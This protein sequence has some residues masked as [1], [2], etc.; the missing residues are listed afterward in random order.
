MMLTVLV[1]AL[2]VFDIHEEHCAWE[3][4]DAEHYHRL[5]WTA[6]SGQ[7]FV[8]GLLPPRSESG[9]LQG[10][11]F[12]R[13]A[14]RQH[15]DQPGGVGHQ[16]AL[17]NCAVGPPG[18]IADFQSDR[19]LL[20]FDPV[21]EKFLLTIERPVLLEDVVDCLSRIQEQFHGGVIYYWP[22]RQEQIQEALT[23]PEGAVAVFIN[24]RDVAYTAYALGTNCGRLRIIPAEDWESVHGEG[25]LTRQDIVV[26]QEAPTNFDVRVAGAITCAPQGPLCHVNLICLQESTPNAFIPGDLEEFAPFAD[27][28]VRYEVR[29]DGYSLR[30]ATPEEAARTWEA[31]RPPALTISVPDL[32]YRELPSLAEI[33][34]TR[35]VQR[36]GGKG[37]HLGYFVPAIP[38]EHRV[39]GFVIPFAHFDDFLNS[40]MREEQ[41][42]AEFLEELFASEEFQTNSTYR[43]EQLEHWQDYMRDHGEV[44]QKLIDALATRIDAVFGATTVKVRFRSSSNAEDALLFPGAGLYW[45]TSACAEDSLD[46]NGNGPCHCDPDEPRERTIGRALRKV[47]AGLY[48]FQA[49]EQRSW[50]GIAEEDVRMGI[51]VTPTFLGEAAN[52]VALTGS[53]SDPCNDRYFVTVQLGEA[54][55][56]RPDPGNL[57]EIDYISREGDGELRVVRGRDSSLV[58]QGQSVMSEEELKELG[59][60]LES[61]ESW[62]QPPA[63][64]SKEL[65]RL[66]IEFKV[67][68]DRT[69]YVKQV[70]PYCLPGTA[71]IVRELTGEEYTYGGDTYVN[72]ARGDRSVFEELA[73][74]SVLRLKESTV[75]LSLTEGVSETPWIE[76]VRYGPG[77]QTY[78]PVKAASAETEIYYCHWIDG[79]ADY[80]WTL[81]QLLQSPEG[82][83][84]SIV[85][86]RYRLKLPLWE[87]PTES[88]SWNGQIEAYGE[89]RRVAS[90]RSPGANATPLHRLTISLRDGS[91][92]AFTYAAPALLSGVDAV[93]VGAMGTVK[94]RRFFIDDP[95]RLA[96]AEGPRPVCSAFLM[97]IGDAAV[98]AVHVQFM[99]GHA[100]PRVEIL[101]SD[102]AVQEE[103]F[104]AEWTRRPF[105]I[106]SDPLFLRGDVTQDERVNTG[107]PIAL[108]EFLFAS[109]EALQCE[110]AAD[111]NDDGH[112]NI[113]DAV[114]LLR[115]LFSDPF[116][117]SNC[118][119][120]ETED[121]LESR[122]CTCPPEK[123]RRPYE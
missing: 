1:L 37:G 24:S 4:N 56:V 117:P 31:R 87:P 64:F 17:Q 43:K 38:E 67:T 53:P 7:E 21:R 80:S 36:F 71:R 18:E 59:R 57:P 113:S 69:I 116:L 13:P 22:R 35:Q 118:G 76:D 28:L 50:H 109:G 45:S 97:V 70:R 46:G 114:S 23:W 11:I 107:D 12:M 83:E 9:S 25:S 115:H 120:D 16:M 92:V 74:R 93:P 90:Y 91:A 66:D 123:L 103:L 121:A 60:V 94:G 98:H 85:G 33:A 2:C 82:E 119:F 88:V 75:P 112:L 81:T 10:P 52:G 89:G 39:P 5:A 72:A 44:S 106:P 77:K 42:Y 110:D 47:W 95:Y 61:L 84:R 6:D 65:V 58:E 8:T 29:Q 26:L 104:V 27:K 68:Q 32:M 96:V 20:I 79:Y 62:Y 30:E 99:G 111:V 101:D 73:D 105:S 78:R 15:S 54:S 41:T 34:G 55:V 100:S 63:P 122:F 3:V 51:L 102:F 40:N 14:V 19:F 108:L 49:V 86:G 48:N